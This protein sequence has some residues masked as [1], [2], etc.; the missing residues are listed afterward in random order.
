MLIHSPP[1]PISE[2]GE[3]RVR[4]GRGFRGRRPVGGHVL[5]SVHYGLL[6]K[7]VFLNT[8][9]YLSR[10]RGPGLL[11]RAAGRWPLRGMCDDVFHIVHKAHA[12]GSLVE[13]SGLSL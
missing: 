10:E 3:E 2:G 8:L 5:G 4:P 1:K 6:I 9:R 13:C 11:G 12:L 7:P